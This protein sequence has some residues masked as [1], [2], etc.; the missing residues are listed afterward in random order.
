MWL[1]IPEASNLT[2]SRILWVTLQIDAI[3]NCATDQGIRQALADLPKDLN[4]TYYRCASRIRKPLGLRMLS[5]ICAT[6]IPFQIAELQEFLAID[7]TTGRIV[8][9][10][11]PKERSMIESCAGLATCTEDNLVLP[12]HH[13]VILFLEKNEIPL[14]LHEGKFDIE[15]SRLALGQLCVRHLTGPD[16]TLQVSAREPKFTMKIV[17]RSFVQAPLLP[18]LFRIPRLFDTTKRTPIHFDA[19]LATTL[20]KP[21]SQIS[22]LSAFRYA[23]ANWALLTMQISSESPSWQHFR[24]IVLER[25]LSWNVLPWS[26]SGRSVDSHYQDLLGWAI[27]CSHIPMLH[28]LL[29]ESVPEPRKEIFDLPLPQYENQ[30]PLELA[31]LAKSTGILSSLLIRCAKPKLPRLMHLAAKAGFH[32]AIDLLLQSLNYDTRYT[33]HDITPLAVAAQFGHHDFVTRL[34]RTRLQ[35]DV[36]RTINSLPHR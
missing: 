21:E 17:P 9:E 22:H 24:R 19:A 20:R 30:L 4:E 11:M 8:R 7:P 6:L 1:W 28:I 5:C 14:E 26:P 16:Y 27:A 13:S 34:F 36:V 2:S 33:L 12:T 35:S 10:N 25:C 15:K 32:D 3:W 23:R 31:M 18:I 29:H